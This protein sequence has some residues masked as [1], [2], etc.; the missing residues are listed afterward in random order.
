M[1]EFIKELD[2]NLDYLE[3]EI[4]ADELSFMCHQIGKAATVPIAIRLLRVYTAAM[5]RA[6]RICPLWGKR[7]KL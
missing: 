6:F 1:D 2:Q 3:H 4:N 7:Q 5:Q